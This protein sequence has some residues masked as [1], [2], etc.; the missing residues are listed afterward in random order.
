MHRIKITEGKEINIFAGRVKVRAK[1][2]Q[3]LGGGYKIGAAAFDVAQFNRGRMQRGSQVI[4]HP[5]P[6]RRPIGLIDGAIV[7]S[8]QHL[9]G[10]L[11]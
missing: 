11:L 8:I 6:I 3:V 4:N 2:V 5:L 1:I 9:Q 10:F 7:A